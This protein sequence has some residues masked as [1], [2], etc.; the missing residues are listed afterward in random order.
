MKGEYC[1]KCWK[2]D[3]TAGKCERYN[4]QLDQIMPHVYR[5]CAACVDADSAKNERKGTAIEFSG[6]GE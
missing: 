4:E 5:R 6:G 3:F 2:L 1:R